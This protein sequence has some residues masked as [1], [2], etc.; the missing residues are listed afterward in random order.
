MNSEIP[1]TMKTAKLKFPVSFDLKVIM[2]SGED[3]ENQ[4]IIINVLNDLKI[5]FSNWDIRES[6]KG[7]YKRY[8]VKIV[9]ITKKRMDDLYSILVC[10]PKVKTVL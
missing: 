3:E 8:S 2:E 5:P 7:N 1:S 4:E 6:S 10:Q 9:L